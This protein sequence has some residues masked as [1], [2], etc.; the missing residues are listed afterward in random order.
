[1]VGHGIFLDE[2]DEILVETPAGIQRMA[3]KQD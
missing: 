3:R 2:A 1:V